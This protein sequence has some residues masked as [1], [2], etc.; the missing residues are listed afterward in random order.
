M[1]SPVTPARGL[2]SRLTPDHPWSGLAR[3]YRTL[4]DL[5]RPQG[6]TYLEF[7]E[8]VEEVCGI[9]PQDDVWTR[10]GQAW[11]ETW[12]E[13]LEHYGKR[14]VLPRGRW[15]ELRALVGSRNGD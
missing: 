9:L 1:H 14:L 10:G 3:Y 12:D 11:F 13:I 4:H 8:V 7:I 15:P 6:P 2:S 5:D